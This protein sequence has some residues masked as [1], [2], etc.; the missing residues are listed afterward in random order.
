[1]GRYKDYSYEQT[2]FLPI[3]FNKQ[4]LPGT[5]EYTL[6][7]LIND[8]LDLTIF[9]ER[10]KN[11]DTGAPAYDP[12]ILLKIILFAY[13]RGIVSSRNIEKLCNEN[14]ICIALTADTHP[15]FTT[16]ADFISS[17]DNE[18]V[19]LFT[20][21]LA[22]C[23]S[24][25]L[26]GKNMFAIDGCKISSNC[27][28]EWSGTKKE[29]LNKSEKI[30]AAIEYLISKHK[31]ADTSLVEDKQ[32]KRE[33]ESIRKLKEKADKISCWLDTH[34]EKLG[35]SNQPKKSNII[36][37][38]SAKMSSSHG[39]IQGYNGIAAVDDKHQLIV[40]AEA[41]GDIHESGHLP[42]ILNGI[43]E[44]CI[45]SGV[46]KKILTKVKITADSGFHNARNMQLV[47]EKNIDA[48]IPDNRF[49]QR[50]I[51]FSDVKKYKKQIAKW[52]P[53][54]KAKKFTPKDFYLDTITGKLICPAG[55]PMNLKVKNL[56]N[57]QTGCTGKAY[58]G[59][60]KYCTNCALRDKCLRK[61][62]TRCRQVVIFDKYSSYGN[63]YSNIMKDRFDTPYAR[64]V[65]SKRMGTV[66][67]VFGHIAGTKKLNRFTLRS[68]KK[69]NNQW[70]LYCIVHNIGK[71]Q[72]YGTA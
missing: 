70:L 50:D 7:L 20:R 49:R 68:K 27:S 67:P 21:V 12:A 57:K 2:V 45:K 46:D 59:R 9:K 22:I 8:K 41:F 1:M 34:E 15:H 66:E 54:C 55:K 3:N 65:Y 61:E 44:N 23:Y 11:D 48:Y 64:S 36:D 29:L 62:T 40:W 28:K 14:I 32:Q 47:C 16:I 38:E 71:I 37:N 52:K 13:S 56:K 43:E 10:Y 31:Q 60:V 5:F 51:R 53:I 25:N 17:M 4:I 39:V 26:I 6:N 18:C 72:R 33:E 58:M 30:K 42:E 63:E 35:A 69:V 19:E 24:E